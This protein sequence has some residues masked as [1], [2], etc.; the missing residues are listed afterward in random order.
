MTVSIPFCA[1]FLSV[2]VCLL[3]R[4]LSRLCGRL[5]AAANDVVCLVDAATVHPRSACAC[6]CILSSVG[7]AQ[8]LIHFC[9]CNTHH[10]HGM[11]CVGWML[12]GWKRWLR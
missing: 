12:F 2:C 4:R 7:A 8:A 11:P 3:R 9:C 6:V 1:F 5:R 10:P